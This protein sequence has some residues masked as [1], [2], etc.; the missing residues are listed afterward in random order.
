MSVTVRI[1]TVMQRH[2]GGQAEVQAQGA[3]VGE[4]LRD[5]A[6]QHEE[7]RAMLFNAAGE[8][9]TFVNVFVNDEDARLLQKLDTP[10][11]SGDEVLLLPAASGGR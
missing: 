9:N 7:A 10:L 1:P 8:V 2:T 11:K 3:T 5:F 4:A 6:S